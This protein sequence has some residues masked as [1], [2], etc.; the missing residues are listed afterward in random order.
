V[1]RRKTAIAKQR[2][3]AYLI[4]LGSSQNVPAVHTKK[5]SIAGQ[6][7]PLRL[8][9]IEQFCK[10]NAAHFACRAVVFSS[11]VDDQRL[12][13]NAVNDHGVPRRRLSEL[14]IEKQIARLGLPH[15]AADEMRIALYEGFR[16]S[17]LRK[18]ALLQILRSKSSGTDAEQ[19]VAERRVRITPS[20]DF[21]GRS[22]DFHPARHKPVFIVPPERFAIGIPQEAC[23]VG[24]FGR[25]IGC[26]PDRLVFRNEREPAAEGGLICRISQ[27]QE[28]RR[29]IAEA[30]SPLECDGGV[31]E[32]GPRA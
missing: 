23:A 10:C 32:C 26:W 7:T 30:V 12:A 8:R 24:D 13:S 15:I 29:A 19:R 3:A 27:A 9:M 6:R 21:T 5:V 14:S 18:H 17:K 28:V 16:I 22:C 31:R 20:V 11:V 4:S 25:Q 2:L 1:Q